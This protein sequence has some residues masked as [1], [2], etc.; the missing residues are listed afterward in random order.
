MGQRVGGEP[1][2]KEG[3]A[4]L[5]ARADEAGPVVMLNLLRFRPDG[6]RARYGEYAAAVGPLLKELGG[7]LLFAGDGAPA[8]IGSGSWDLVLLVEYPSRKAFLGMIGSE[9]YREIAHLRTEALSASELHPL[10][11][12]AI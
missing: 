9:R 4:A 7:R 8:L 10:E 2:G 11:Q 1:F 3:F 12:A 5:A 6:G